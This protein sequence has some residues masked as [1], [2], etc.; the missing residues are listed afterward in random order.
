MDK[1]KDRTIIRFTKSMPPGLGHSIERNGEQ[2]GH[3]EWA[4]D[5]D[6]HCWLLVLPK[7]EEPTTFQQVRKELAGLSHRH[8]DACTKFLDRLEVYVQRIPNAT[9]DN[10]DYSSSA[11]IIREK[12]EIMF[13]CDTKRR[14]LTLIFGVSDYRVDL[15]YI[16]EH[17][18]ILSQS[19]DIYNACGVA[20][21]LMSAL[22][23]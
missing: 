5:E 10:Y 4:Q 23:A 11:S 12:I 14:V 20:T 13:R 21:I 16:D 15:S 3:G 18:N 9:V 17:N 6:T 1:W 2:I 7:D 22:T 8:I 19:C